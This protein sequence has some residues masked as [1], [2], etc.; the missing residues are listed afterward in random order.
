M[1]HSKEDLIV[2]VDSEITER[3]KFDERETEWVQYDI[4]NGGPRT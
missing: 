4:I 1:L 2:I 3:E